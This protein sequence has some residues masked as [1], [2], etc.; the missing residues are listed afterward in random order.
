MKINSESAAR[1]GTDVLSR[2]LEASGPR[3]SPPSRQEEKTQYAVRFADRMAVEMARDLAGRLPGIEA[4]TKRDSPTSK[5][6]K[7][8]DINFSTPKLG[9]ALGISLKSVHVREQV[10]K[11]QSDGTT[12]KVPG[13][14][15]HNLKRND[16]EL[17]TEATVYHERQPYAVMLGVFFLPFESCTDGRAREPVSS[18]GSWVRKLRLRTGRSAPD[19]RAS[20]FEKIYIALYEPDGSELR[21]FDVQ[22]APPKN[23][24]PRRDGEL[25]GEDGFPRRLL[26]YEEFLEAAYQ[27][28]QRRNHTEFRWDDGQVEVLS[29]DND[30]E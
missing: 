7:Q 22:S 12:T 26:T 16:E 3:P 6:A 23:S 10:T 8:L 2:V 15:T 1:S 19:D 4:T 21:F 25:S 28:Y 18:F 14:Y 5:G 13:R 20:L 27:A 17:A 24:I 30:D 29:P 11:K 9:L